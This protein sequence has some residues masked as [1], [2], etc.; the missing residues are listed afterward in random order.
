MN[1]LA[2]L[3]ALMIAVAP[4]SALA[5]VPLPTPKPTVGPS[6][7][8]AAA[9]DRFVSA[10]TSATT[11]TAV[12]AYAPSAVN[13]LQQTIEARQS[14]LYVVGKL[15]ERG[16]PIGDGLEWRVFRDFPDA[17]GQL[18]LVHRASGGDLEVR[19]GEGRY[20]V[21]LAYGRAALS[22][23]VQVG[24][25]VTSET[26]VLNAGGLQLDAQIAG[27]NGPSGNPM[28][29][30]LYLT[31]G[32]ERRMIGTVKRGA[33]ARLPAGSYHVVSRYGDL[34][35]VRTADVV[36]EAGKLTRV[37]MRHT[38]G[39]INLRLVRQTGGEAIAN[40]EFS[41]YTDDGRRVYDRRGAHATATLA[42]GNYA[43]VARHRDE[44]FSQSFTVRS[45][46]TGDIDILAQRLRRPL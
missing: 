34:N 43:V 44:E 37:S 10:P 18:P 39:T 23:V 28:S 12:A 22:R 42:A 1:R 30:A 20:I 40:T 29:F 6:T 32:G 46:A 3:A 9:L 4:L 5:A 19:L 11:P 38:A 31:E 41:I 45:G 15:S 33:I 2:Q 21:H 26:M 36:V 7:N 25:R 35:A 14:T 24:G 27:A 16:G 8:A 13:P 17:N